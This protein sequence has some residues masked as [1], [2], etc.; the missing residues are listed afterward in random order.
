MKTLAFFCFFL[1]LFTISCQKSRGDVDAPAVYD[2]TPGPLMQRT[3]VMRDATHKDSAWLQLPIHYNSGFD[4]EKYP[5]MIYFNG[6]FES[7]EFGNLNVMKDIGVPKFMA[8]SLRFAFDTGN[9][10]KNMIVLAPQ[11]DNGY[12]SPI[13]INQTIDYMVKNYRVDLS[14]IYLVGISS[15]AA[16]MFGYLTAKQEYADRIAAVVPMSSVQLTSQQITNLK[17]IANTNLPTLVY[18]GN[19]DPLFDDNKTYVDA[20][21]Q[22]KPGLATFKAYAGAHNNWNKMFDPSNRYYNPNIYEWLLQY[23]N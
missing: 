14:R 13:S 8:D 20:I 21:N 17:F 6:K 2:S 9:R 1:S 11:S 7:A 23:S 15:G 5:L 12:P 19:L 16:S 18:C 4:T 3:T 22:Y 10:A